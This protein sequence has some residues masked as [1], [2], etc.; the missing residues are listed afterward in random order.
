MELLIST[1]NK[2]IN[3]LMENNVR[4]NAIG[5]LDQLPAKCIKNL[6]TP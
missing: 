4:L 5:D 6:T 2:E 3:K 1:I